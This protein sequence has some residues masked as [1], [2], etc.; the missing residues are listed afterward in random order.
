MKRKKKK[1]VGNLP[2][3]TVKIRWTQTVHK[4]K[5]GA[6]EAAAEQEGERRWIIL[7]Y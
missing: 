4:S 5:D 3:S 1:D 2:A 7:L 6:E